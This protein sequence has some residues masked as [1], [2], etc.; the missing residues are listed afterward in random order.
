MSVVHV[1]FQ[2][3]RLSLVLHYTLLVL[4]MGIFVLE[5]QLNLT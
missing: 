3:H 1:A 4:L 5:I 2:K